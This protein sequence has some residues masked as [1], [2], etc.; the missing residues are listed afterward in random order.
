MT[1]MINRLIRGNAASSLFDFVFA[2]CFSLHDA[3]NIETILEIIVAMI[4]IMMLST[5][6]FRGTENVSFSSKTSIEIIGEKG[7]KTY[8]EYFPTKDL[9]V[10]VMEALTKSKISDK[11]KITVVVYGGGISAQ[12]DAIR[13]G[14]ARGL[15]IFDKELR[16]PIKKL[17]FLK[18]DPRAKERRKFGLKKARKAPQWSKR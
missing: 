17:G 8:E 6:L 10:T 1:M 11:Y 7:T 13:L 4:R 2:A 16:K 3:R 14:I 5:V 18:R 15:I 9:Q 12:A